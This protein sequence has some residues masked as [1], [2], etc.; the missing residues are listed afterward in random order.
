M[1]HRRERT[2][3]AVRS[4]YWL[5]VVVGLSCSNTYPQIGTQLDDGNAVSGSRHTIVRCDKSTF[6]LYIYKYHR[7]I[8]MVKKLIHF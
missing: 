5:Y 8:L 1:V 7:T 4:R 3:I 6:S 2:G